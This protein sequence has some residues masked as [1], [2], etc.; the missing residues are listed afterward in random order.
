MNYYDAVLLLVP[1]S[2]LSASGTAFALGV[3]VEAA[4]M[5]GGV[6]SV[7]IIGHSMFANPPVDVLQ[8]ETQTNSTSLNTDAV[9]DD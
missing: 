5:I 6:F 9:T 1:L 3:S 7:A 8:P 2:F 4:V